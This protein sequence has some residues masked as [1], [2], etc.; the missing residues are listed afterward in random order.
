MS[1]SAV[2]SR[3]RL[4]EL[5]G[6][7]G[8]AIVLVVLSH[9]WVLWPMDFIDTHEWVRPLFRSGNSAV[10]V[11]LVV[12]GFVS[13]RGLAHPSGLP[14]MQPVISLA[15]R[16]IRVA[17]ALIAMLVALM[18]VAAIDDTDTASKD[19]NRSTLLHS[20]TY[21]YNWYVQDSFLQTRADLGHLW[22]LSV[23]MQAFV[24]FA[25]LA[26]LLRRRPLGLALSLAGL[27]LL[28]VWWRFHA[29]NTEVIWTVLNRTSVR[30]DAFIIGA[31]A[32]AVVTYLPRNQPAY[33]WIGPVSLVLMLPTLM[34]CDTDDGYMGWGG[35]FL[36]IL[37]AV[38]VVS[39]AMTQHDPAPSRF[40]LMS[41]PVLVRLGAMS[42]V[43]YVWHL[44][45]FHFVHRHTEHWSW[46]GW[47]VLVA[48]AATWAISRV[49]ERLIEQPISGVLAASWWQEARSR[50]LVT[51]ARERGAA[52]PGAW[53]RVI[54]APAP[55]REKT[56]VG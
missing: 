53:A 54:W 51:Y 19:T 6:L 1:E 11:F 33:R 23:D 3:R 4:R 13:Y 47:S 45:I 5:D 28:L 56:R 44:P 24:C 36:E 46:W 17:P 16:V 37:V 29:Y 8:I 31:L 21:T 55:K 32:A 30:M 50:G 25:L 26:Y 38:Y 52:R 15:R 2:E 20:I 42:L 40:R 39:V 7:R 43:L 9:G 27:F 14:R 12:S 10:T 48:L 49:C 34:W 41:H 35:T 22:Y 18:V